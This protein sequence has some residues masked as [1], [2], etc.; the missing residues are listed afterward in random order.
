M[1]LGAGGPVGNARIKPIPLKISRRCSAGDQ[2]QDMA[3][4]ARAPISHLVTTVCRKSCVLGMEILNY[5]KH[6]T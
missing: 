4:S 5:Y 1:G 6:L 2:T 3:A